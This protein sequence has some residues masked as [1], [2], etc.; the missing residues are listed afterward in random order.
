MLMNRI[1]PVITSSRNWHREL[2]S[3]I[4]HI[5]MRNFPEVL[6]ET[7]RHLVSFDINLTATYKHSYKPIVVLST[8]SRQQSAPLAKYLNEF[9]LLDPLFN[10]LQNGLGAGVYR[11]REI[12][13]DSFEQSEFYRSCYR[14][15]DPGDEINL[16][17]PLEND[18]FFTISLG[19]PPH[20]GAITRAERNTLNSVFPV[21]SALVRQ[22]WIVQSSEYVHD[23]QV[24]SSMEHALSTF[25]SGVLTKREQE[26][27]GL[28]L[29]GHSSKSIARQLGISA[30]TVKVHRK[31]IHTRL[32]TSTQSELF[33][34]FLGHLSSLAHP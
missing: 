20:L 3:L 14:E 26:I 18:V 9:Y 10:A 28:I 8:H 4:D 31:N 21:I 29:Q 23:E 6:D 5:R 16:V 34:L 11:L 17:F 25:G 1:D 33:S 15:F 30:G 19:R 7:L 24:R 2:A 12:A 27:T 22:F 32:N 13:P